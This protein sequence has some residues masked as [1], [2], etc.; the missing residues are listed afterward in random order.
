M[1]TIELGLS[2]HKLV[3][4]VLNRKVTE[5]K[6]LFTMAKCFKNFDKNAFNKDLECVSFGV[7]YVS[8]EVDDIC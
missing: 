1:G 7:A 5:Q 4:N 6:T 8:D 2:D 3:Y